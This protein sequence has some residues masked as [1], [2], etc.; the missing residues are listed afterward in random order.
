MKQTL[1]NKIAESKFRKVLSKQ[2]FQNLRLFDEEYDK[3][4]MQNIIKERIHKSVNDFNLLK[5]KS[6]LLSPFLEI[7]AGYCQSSLV[8]TNRYSSKGFALD[9][10]I[11][12][13]KMLNKV[14]IKYKMYKKP[15]LV[16]GD[17]ENL[18]FSKNSFPFI[19]TY[20]TVHH[21]PT[22]NL[23]FK[24]IYRV[25]TPGGT[26]LMAEEPIKQTLNFNIWR[27]PTKLRL[28]EKILKVCLILPF[29]SKIGRTEVNCG[30]IEGDFK[31]SEWTRALEK[32]DSG[33]IEISPYPYG[34]KSWLLWHDGVW[35]KSKLTN[36]TSFI[37][38][39]TGGGITALV[40]KKGELK[41]YNLPLVACPKCK[42]VLINS[43]KNTYKCRACEETYSK[44]GNIGVLL[45][46]K[47]KDLLY[48][49]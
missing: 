31:I 2:H 37:I 49:Q 35:K 9:I 42:L 22:P 34:P 16:V 39:F 13:L 33:E 48:P 18:P 14:S 44:E 41:N 1:E 11:D 38:Y 29:V 5:K 10:A 19:F 25:L 32:F 20:Q 45:S 28:W 30:I 27:R 15:S 43:S 40:K 8:L 47:L 12:P 23:V 4:E 21:F 46:G 7:G 17:A 24:E 36:L 6:V 3:K 26:F